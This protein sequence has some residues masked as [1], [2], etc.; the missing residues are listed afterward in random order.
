[1]RRAED[2]KP[3]IRINVYHAA[4]DGD[5]PSIGFLGCCGAYHSGI[6]INGSEYSFGAGVG[7]YECL[8]GDYGEVVHTETIQSSKSNSE[9]K[10]IID[11]L[12]TEFQGN[13]YHII[14]K[15]CNS[16]S[17]ALIL[18]CT[19]NDR[20]FPPWINRAA[21]YASWFKPCF[22]ICAIGNASSEAQ[23]L[24]TTA[25]GREPPRQVAP[26]FSGE[27]MALNAGRSSQP[28]RPLSV[29]EQRAVRLRNLSGT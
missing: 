26:M 18:A 22:Y 19:E 23:P 7:V 1:M 28:S 2:L 17:Q 27:G 25:A 9:V 15:N 4:Q 10:R 12:R 8:P 3:I 14:L 11:K 24:L 5:S 29:E 20:N 21:W 6:E 13:Q 16:F